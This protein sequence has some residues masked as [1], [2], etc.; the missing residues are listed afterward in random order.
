MVKTFDSVLA[1]YEGFCHLKQVFLIFSSVLCNIQVLE[2]SLVF[3]LNVTRG[4]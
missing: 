1:A 3:Q 4:I 2:L